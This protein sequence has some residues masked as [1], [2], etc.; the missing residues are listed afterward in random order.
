MMRFLV[1]DKLQFTLEEIRQVMQESVYPLEKDFLNHA[2][3]FNELVPSLHAVR[4][5]VKERGL[6]APFLAEKYGGMG[7][8]LSE[9]AYLSEELG[10]SPIG[11]YIF[12]C[13]APDVGNME[14][15][16]EHGNPSQKEEYKDLLLT[17]HK[18]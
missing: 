18:A 5:R 17:L 11:H 1:S 3:G 14:L 2:I 4:Q 15:L 13:Q 12:N 16:I 8:T 9:Y 10:R 6:W 7:F